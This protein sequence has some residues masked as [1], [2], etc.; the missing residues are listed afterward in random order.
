MFSLRTSNSPWTS[1]ARGLN[2]GT[3][4]PMQHLATHSN[5]YHFNGQDKN[6][7]LGLTQLNCRVICPKKDSLLVS[8]FLCVSLQAGG[9]K[10]KLWLT[11]PDQIPPR[12]HLTAELGALGKLPLSRWHNGTDQIRGIPKSPSLSNP[13]PLSFC[14]TSSQIYMFNCSIAHK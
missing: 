7:F 4:L 11:P 3:I 9:R 14:E 1:A 2:R 8:L 5:Y 13:R 6:E 10:K 12:S